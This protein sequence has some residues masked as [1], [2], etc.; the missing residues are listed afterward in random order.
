MEGLCASVDVSGIKSSDGDTT[1]HGHIDGVLVSAF[2]D[3]LLGESS[4]GEHTDLF[5]DVAPVVLVSVGLNLLDKGRSHFSDSAGHESEVVV[6][7]LGEL[8]VSKDDVDD[9][10]AVDRGVG[11]NW[12]G[13]LL[14]S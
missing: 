5:G 3:G 14:Q 2:D 12:S 7:H 4:V 8:L 11:V 10:S 9:S 1:V 6:P 13:D